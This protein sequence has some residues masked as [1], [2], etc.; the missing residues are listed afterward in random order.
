MGEV[1]HDGADRAITP[2]KDDEVIAPA[3]CRMHRFRQPRWAAQG[4]GGCD[5]DALCLQE[6]TRLCGVMLTATGA[7][8]HDEGGT[9]VCSLTTHHLPVVLLSLS[10][11]G[12]LRSSLAQ[13]DESQMRD[14]PASHGWIAG[15]TESDRGYRTFTLPRQP[16]DDGRGRGRAGHGDALRL[17]IQVG[18]ELRPAR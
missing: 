2:S 9:P 15:D 5:L 3:Q 12:P 4:V 18:L 7:G 16:D 10:E 11:P 17:A 8:V 13:C 1:I 6:P 14:A